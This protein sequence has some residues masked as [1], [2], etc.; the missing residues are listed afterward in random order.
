MLPWTQV[1]IYFCTCILFSLGEYQVAGWYG[2]SIFSFW[3]TAV[4]FPQQLHRLHLTNSAWGSPFLHIFTR[5][6][7]FF[8]DTHSDRMKW[9]FI[10]VL[11]SLVISDVEHLLTCLFTHGRLYVFGKTF[12]SSAHFVVRWFFQCWVVCILSMLVGYTVCRYILPFS[13]LPFISVD[14]FRHPQKLF[15]SLPAA[16]CLHLSSTLCCC[17]CSTLLFIP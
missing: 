6:C 4:L 5:A 3:G 17:C 11:I 16:R 13:R 2:S 1:C 8:Y 9:Y 14:S 12:R 7:S 15:R 10:A